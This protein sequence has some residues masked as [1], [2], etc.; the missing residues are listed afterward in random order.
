[1]IAQ[2]NGVRID[3]RGVVLVSSLLLL[4]VVTIMALSMF[5]SFG[6]QEKIAGN[7]REKQRALQAAESA[8]VYAEQWLITN[9]AT[10]PVVCA[11]PLNAN[12]GQG[13]ICSNK[14]WT[15]VANNNVA[16]VPWQTGA[17]VNVGV[18]TYLPTNMNVGAAS[19]SNPNSYFRVP[20][21]YISDAGASADA[22]V[23]GEIFQ[24]DAVGYGGNGNTASVVESTFAVYSSSTNRGGP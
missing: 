15:I 16:I 21:F 7:M 8:Q 20:S 10:A 9:S 18:T 14:L 22:G 17:G 23:P 5:R 11:G 19:V 13:Q 24:V 12:L 1:M 3:Q 6:M 2:R 4:L